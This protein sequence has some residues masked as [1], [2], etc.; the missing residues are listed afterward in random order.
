MHRNINKQSATPAFTRYIPNFSFLFSHDTH[1]LCSEQS[2]FSYTSPLDIPYLFTLNNIPGPKSKYSQTCWQ[3]FPNPLSSIEHCVAFPVTKFWHWPAAVQRGHLLGCAL[4]TES[5]RIRLW[6]RL[7]AFLRAAGRGKAHTAAQAS[8]VEAHRT[9]RMA[10]FII[11]Q[12]STSNQG[13][14]LSFCVEK[15]NHKS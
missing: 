13:W 4:A 12:L 11:R 7:F 3:A 8:R 2:C 9:C 14:L 5:S 10:C 6:L 15:W 1:K